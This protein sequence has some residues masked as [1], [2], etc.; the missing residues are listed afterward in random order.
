MIEFYI[1]Y[2]KINGYKGKGKNK[3]KRTLG[4]TYGTNSIYAGKHYTERRKDSEFW[5]L[6]V[7]KHLREQGI[8]KQVFDKPVEI[9]CS[10]DD[11][12]DSDNHSYMQKLI[13]NSLL[14]V[15]KN[16]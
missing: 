7:L 14:T 2:P 4:N 10:F 9:I 6:W 5:H 3:V 11:K 8:K 15:L 16:I 1:A 13:K 12:L